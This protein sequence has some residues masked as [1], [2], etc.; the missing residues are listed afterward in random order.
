MILLDGAQENGGYILWIT[1]M[2]D[3]FLW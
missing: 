1:F 2:Q 3:F